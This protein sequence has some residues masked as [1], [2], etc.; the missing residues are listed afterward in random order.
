LKKREAKNEISREAKYDQK[1]FYKKRKGKGL[2]EPMTK[3]ALD[4]SKKFEENLE[5]R[6]GALQKSDHGLEF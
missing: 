6:G 2:T 1:M 3:N 5:I 4:L